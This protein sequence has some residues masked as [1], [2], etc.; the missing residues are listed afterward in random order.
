MTCGSVTGCVDVTVGREVSTLEDKRGRKDGQGQ[1]ESKLFLE[2][3]ATVCDGGM[4]QQS[5]VRCCRTSGARVPGEV[6]G[7]VRQYMGTVA[8]LFELGERSGGAVVTPR[9]NVPAR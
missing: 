7:C 4:M 1:E 5:R 6:A 9:E 8:A 2:H 3:V